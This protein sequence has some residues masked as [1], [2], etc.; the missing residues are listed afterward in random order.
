[1]RTSCLT[2]YLV[3]PSERACR[4]RRCPRR[5]VSAPT[6]VT[7]VR[8]VLS[9]SQLRTVRDA[10]PATA[11]QKPHRRASSKRLRLHPCSSW[12]SQ[13]RGKRD[14]SLREPRRERS[15]RRTTTSVCV[16]PRQPRSRRPREAEE[17]DRSAGTCRP[18][19]IG[20]TRL[21]GRDREDGGGGPGTFAFQALQQL[22][23]P[24]ERDPRE[25]A[26]LACHE[27]IEVRAFAAGEELGP[28]WNRVAAQSPGGGARC[29]GHFRVA[30]DSL[31]P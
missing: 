21:H 31:W 12:T 5:E 23:D 26:V 10:Q 28:A 16:R 1:L 17:R 25:P 22:V 8:E 11:S 24:E 3:R 14:Q 18:A 6:G 13:H 4:I 2:Q 20:R 19:W 7:V 29:D 27:L 30:A 9:P 15:P